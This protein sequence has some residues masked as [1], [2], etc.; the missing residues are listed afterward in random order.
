MTLNDLERCNSAYFAFF[1]PNSIALQADY[2]TLVEDRPIMFLKYCLL[3]PVFHFCSK[4]RHPAARSLCDSWAFCYF[5]SQ[6]PLVFHFYAKFEV[7][8]LNRSRD[9]EGYQDFKSRS[10][11]PFP[12]LWPNFH[13]FSLVPLVVI[14]H[15]K[16]EFSSSNCFRDMEGSQNSK[17]RSRDPFTTCKLQSPV[18]RYLD[19]ST[20]SY[21]CI[22]QL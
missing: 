17:I 9:T 18:T 19:S 2:V 22:I 6:E 10:R 20:L 15:A 11:D 7:S 12:T 16:F 3:V 13:F 21:I 14:L 8:R 4:L 1:S 5:L